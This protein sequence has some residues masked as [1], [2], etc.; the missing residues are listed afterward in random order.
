MFA[1]CTDEMKVVMFS[2]LNCDT[3]AFTVLPDITFLASDAV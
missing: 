2:L 3:V 1:V